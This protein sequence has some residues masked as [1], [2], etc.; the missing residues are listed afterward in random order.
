MITLKEW[1]EFNHPVNN[2]GDV[3]VAILPHESYNT[4]DRLLYSLMRLDNAVALF[5]DLELRKF[6]V[7]TIPHGSLGMHSTIKVVL[8]TK[9]EQS[10]A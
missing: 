8:W 4:D 2:Q 5:G 7:G 10:N 1:A 6:S 3:I 9:E